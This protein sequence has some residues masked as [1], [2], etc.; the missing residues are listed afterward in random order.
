MTATAEV[1]QGLQPSAW[2]ALAPLVAHAWTMA[3]PELLSIV[4]VRTA[5]LNGTTAVAAALL[6]PPSSPRYEQARLSVS[7]WPSSPLFTPLERACLSFAEQMQIDPNAM[8]AG[9]VEALREHMTSAEVLGFASALFLLD[10]HVR[11]LA[12]MSQLLHVGRE[13]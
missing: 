8:E 2:G 5:Q 1:L 9:Q 3:D 12:V 7:D 10:A 4:L 6:P 11:V 13:V